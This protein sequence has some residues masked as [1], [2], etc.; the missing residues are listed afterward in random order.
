MDGT[1]VAGDETGGLIEPRGRCVTAVDGQ[2]KP[3]D[4]GLASSSACRS[5]ARPRP[6]PRAAGVKPR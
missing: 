4:V 2:L 6:Q 3:G 5:T 1:T